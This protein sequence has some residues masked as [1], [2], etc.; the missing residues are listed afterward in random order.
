MTLDS[1]AT[2]I[3]IKS[4]LLE[5]TLEQL[6]VLLVYNLAGRIE[7]YIK[8]KKKKRKWYSSKSMLSK[9]IISF[10]FCF[11]SYIFGITKGDTI[12]DSTSPACGEYTLTDGNSA[13]GY[14]CLSG[15]TTTLVP[16]LPNR[17][18]IKFIPN[19]PMKLTFG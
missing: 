15:V 5:G 18:S 13:N 4:Y 1:Y 19:I 12:A 7:Y 8:K 3:I 9:S 11:L 16:R 14:I 10:F 17:I 6:M 2:Q